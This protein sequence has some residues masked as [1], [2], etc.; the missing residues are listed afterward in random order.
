MTVFAD[1]RAGA[2]RGPGV[3]HGPPADIGADIDET[4]HQ[5]AAR[6]DIGTLAGDGAGHHPKAGVDEAGFIPAGKFARH[7]VESGVTG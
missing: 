2:D 4:G 7:L 1:L 6:R 3:D 5:H